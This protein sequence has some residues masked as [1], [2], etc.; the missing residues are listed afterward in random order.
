VDQKAK[1][2]NLPVRERRC[3]FEVLDF[4]SFEAAILVLSLEFAGV[5]DDDMSDLYVQ[6]IMRQPNR[7]K[8]GRGPEVWERR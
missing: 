5:I 1:Y 6:M 4:E 3:I 7:M 8:A 2:K